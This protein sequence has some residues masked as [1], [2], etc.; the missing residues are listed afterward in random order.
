MPA[1]DKLAP[2]DAAWLH[3][4]SPTNLMVITGVLW[5]DAP[6]D[7]DRLL[8]VLAER[9]VEP[10]PKFRMRVVERPLAGAYWEP[11][12]AFSLAAQVERVRLPAPGGQDQLQALVGELMAAPLDPARPLWRA[13]LADGFGA[14]C[15]L[16]VRLHH[17]I[18]DGISLAR[19]LISLA[20]TTADG[21]D[22]MTEAGA[23][24]TGAQD[25]D[26]HHESSLHRAAAALLDTG[27]AAF[28]ALHDAR[29]LLEH[30]GRLAALAGL[31]AQ[32]A[33]ALAKLVLIGPDRPS[34]LRGPLGG[35][36]RCAWTRPIPL[37]Q[38]KRIGQAECATVNDVLLAGVTG[39]LHHYL[40]DE[41]S[42]VPDIRAVVPVNLRP[43]DQP[44]P[45]EL[46]NRFGLVF[47]D[48]PVGLH[49]RPARLQTLKRRMDLIKHSPEAIVAYG[50]LYAIGMTPRQ[51]ERVIVDIFGTKAT[52]V[53]TNV[54]GPRAPIYLAGAKVAGV[55]FW[56]PASANVALG[57]SIFS[58]DGDVVLGLAADAAVIPEPARI[59]AAFEAELASA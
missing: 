9:L 34:C 55:M 47:L 31:G 25:R 21:D 33:A 52:A 12:P 10:Y 17:C 36:K 37:A 8:A 24:S 13:Y 3:M 22:R 6:L 40:L 58:Y 1:L 20:D 14:G 27:H 29:E 4:E 16:I 44:V 51:I 59:L 32:G 15:A 53:M 45:R 26:H 57:L 23:D 18:A 28:T 48:L 19:L 2:V 38:V 35:V 30:P 41:H 43:L 54:P 46:G 7:W 50:M 11:D 5:F 39:A 42:L 56:P 49:S